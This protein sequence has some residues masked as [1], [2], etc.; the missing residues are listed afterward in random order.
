MVPDS[1]ADQAERD[2]IADFPSGQL[3]NANAG[4]GGRSPGFKLDPA[5]REKIAKSQTGKAG[6]FTGMKHSEE[7]KEKMSNAK[8]GNKHCAGRKISDKHKRAL[9]ES[10]PHLDNIAETTLI[11]LRA[12]GYTYGEL[13]EVFMISPSTA[14]N[15]VSK[16]AA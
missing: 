14:R 7:T 3:T 15:T 5:H 6:K 1:E 16:L 12:A 9:Y 10:K 11:E 13:A 2:W 4:G 8:K